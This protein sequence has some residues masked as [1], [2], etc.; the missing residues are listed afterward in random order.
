[1]V[2][3][4]G[5]LLRRRGPLPGFGSRALEF[6]YANSATDIID[7]HGLSFSSCSRS[8]VLQRGNNIVFIFDCTITPPVRNKQPVGKV[9]IDHQKKLFMKILGYVY[10]MMLFSDSRNEL[11]CATGVS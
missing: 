9:C 6:A 4:I 2:V 7:L 11:E 10:C 3:A 5:V 1:M 8:R